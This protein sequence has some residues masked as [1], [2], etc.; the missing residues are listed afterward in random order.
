MEIDTPTNLA[1][2]PEVETE[3]VVDAPELEAAEQED[4]NPDALLGDDSEEVDYE[5]NRYK[6]PKA[7]VPALMKNQD[8]TQ[9]TQALAEERRAFEETYRAERET[10][11]RETE[12]Q[13]ALIDDVSQDRAIEGRLQYL[14]TV[15]P[16][17]LDPQQAQQYWN[18]FNMLR[19]SKDEVTNRIESRKAELA[20]ERERSDANT[21]R[22]AINALKQPDESLG[23]S[24]NYDEPTRVRLTNVAKELGVTDQQI[25]AIRDPITIKALNLASIGL[26][27][28]K[29]QRAALKT[30]K[31]EAKPV[32]Q[33]GASRTKG[34]VDP[35]KMSADEWAKWRN[36]QVYGKSA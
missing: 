24:G 16:N 30:T 6:I 12:V 29:K 35:D 7:L 26:E 10:F 21:L 4:E 5:G 9:K 36:K 32:P 33:V 23:W 13:Q 34:V 19:A 25:A 20:A 27:T 8:Y 11:Q 18:E 22:Q 28:L 1:E 17:T 3:T 31:P 15:N 2:T 14:K